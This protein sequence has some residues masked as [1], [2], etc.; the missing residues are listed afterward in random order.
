[1]LAYLSIKQENGDTKPAFWLI[2]EIFILTMAVTA[3]NHFI[4]KESSEYGW[5]FLTILLC[6]HVIPNMTLK[7]ER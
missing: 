5:F 3:F 7:I 2:W 4:L 1:M 6:M